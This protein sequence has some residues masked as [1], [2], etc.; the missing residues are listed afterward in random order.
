MAPSLFHACIFFD[1]C[2]FIV[3][4]PLDELFY[5]NIS[6]YPIDKLSFVCVSCAVLDRGSHLLIITM[7][8]WNGKANEYK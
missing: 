7:I 1:L 8:T 5:W 2:L 3:F 4:A 6:I